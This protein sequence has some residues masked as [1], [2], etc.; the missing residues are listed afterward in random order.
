MTRTGCCCCRGAQEVWGGFQRGVDGGTSA[1]SSA[2]ASLMTTARSFPRRR[3][4]RMDLSPSLCASP[5]RGAAIEERDSGQRWLGAPAA[6]TAGGGGIA[7]FYLGTAARARLRAQ[8][9]AAVLMAPQPATLRWRCRP[10]FFSFV[11]VFLLMRPD[12]NVR[13]VSRHLSH[14]PT[15]AQFRSTFLCR[16]GCAGC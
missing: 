15:R 12:Q 3:E 9:A 1:Q 14:S 2:R 10:R 4:R 5:T 7:P 6:A 16:E 11:S 13:A 8:C